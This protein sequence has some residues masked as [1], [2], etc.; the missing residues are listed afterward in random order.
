MIFIPVNLFT[1]ATWSKTV[2]EIVF[3][4]FDGV[5]TDNTVYVSTNGSEMV[6]CFRGDGIG[7]GM[8]K[9]SGINISIISAEKNEVVAFRGKKM[10]IDLVY[11]GV[12]D[13]L[14]I[15]QNVLDQ[16]GILP[17]N[18]CFMGN[19]IP[20]IPAMEYVGFSACPSDAEPGVLKLA[21][22]ITPRKGGRGCVRDLCNYL[23]NRT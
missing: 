22:F 15:V 8:L 23:L 18:A 5:L 12:E 9:T 17:S 10:G 13:K 4:D 3:L 16:L 11:S 20:D 6:R 21:K 19:D 1:L 2:I 7:L 14:S